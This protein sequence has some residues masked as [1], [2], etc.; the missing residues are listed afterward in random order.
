M[1]IRVGETFWSYASQYWELYNEI[2]GGNEKIAVCT[3]RMGLPEDSEL[4]KSLTRRPPEDIRQLI[5]HIEE[6]KRLE[7]DRLQSKGKSPLVS[8]PRQSGFQSRPRR[9]LRI[10]ESKLQLGEMNMTFKEP[11]NKIVDRIKNELYL[12]W[13]NKMGETRPRGIRTCIASIT[14]IRSIPPSSAGC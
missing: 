1:K 5:R 12:R 9:D 4:R 11:V 2:S 8:R 10:Q 6:Y 7:N 14:R 13:P 3:F